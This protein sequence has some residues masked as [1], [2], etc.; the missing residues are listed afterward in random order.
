MKKLTFL[1][2]L[3][4]SC[5]FVS[6][7]Q[8]PLGKG[9]KQFNAGFGLSNYGLPLY[10]GADFGV[11]PDITIG[12]VV[13]YRGYS[14]RYFGREYNLSLTTIG[15]NGNYHFNRILE[16]P[17]E[18]DFY[19]GLT[20]SYYI[21]SSPNAYRGTLGSGLGLDA[22]VGGRYFFTKRFAANLEVGGGT[23]AGGRLGITYIF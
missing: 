20:L 3:I 12:P 7:A 5:V 1:C 17:S 23:A 6:H 16:I 18:F 8:A 22:Q 4:F 10:I 11:H 9:G 19:A 2:A 15:F 14:D 21:W 13:S